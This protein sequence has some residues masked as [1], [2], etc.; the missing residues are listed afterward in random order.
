MAFERSAHQSRA[1]GFLAFVILTL[2][3]SVAFGATF[4]LTGTVDDALGRPIAGASVVIEDRDG[5]AVARTVTDD[6]GQFHASVHGSGPYTAVAQKAG[7]RRAATALP[8][9]QRAANPT[10]LVLESEHPL[11]VPVSARLAP[12]NGLS[13]AGTSKYTLTSRDIDNLPAGE[14]TQ[15]NQVMLQMPGVALDQNQEIH[16]RG[17]HM[18]IQYQM[19]GVL[20]PLDMNNDPTFTQLLNS[21]FVRSVSLID[22]V[23]PAQYGYRTAGVIDIHTRDGCEG[24]SQNQFTI[25]GGQRDTV[26]PTFQLGGC[27]SKFSYYVTG[28]FLQSNLGLSSAVPAP[29][30]IHDAV[31][32]GQGFAY[33]GYQA[34]DDLRFSLITGMTVA[35]NQFPNQ[36]NLPAQFTLDHLNPALYPSSDIDSSLDQQD[37]YG[38]FALNGVAGP[39][40]DYQTAYSVHYDNQ[41]FNPDPIGDLIYQGISSK[42]FNSDLSNSLAADVTWRALAG[43]QLRGGAYL[44]E[45]GVESDQTSKVFPIVGG[46]PLVAPIQVEAN[47]NKINLVYGVYLQ[48]SWQLTDKL[49]VNFGSRWDRVSGFVND[50]QFS[51]T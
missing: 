6:R 40:L 8:L 14:A 26:Q 44:G 9:P 7:Y 23:L 43:H 37:Y 27:S 28:L 12:Q 39:N 36:P 32:Q 38:V 45:Y 16:I 21:Y 41:T 2:V 46:V 49:S 35:F 25:L 4:T 34:R 13:A 20:L 47:L 19:N 22:G 42:V 48:D 5:H 31:T 50:S 11:T 29:D 3:W 17:E 33:L 1:I 10:V 18:G 15:L 51:P 30:P 24:S